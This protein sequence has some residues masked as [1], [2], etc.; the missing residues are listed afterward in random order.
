MAIRL[1]ITHEVELEAIRRAEAVGYAGGP[2]GSGS[3]P[4]ERSPPGTGV[5]DDT[6]I[7][8]CLVLQLCVCVY[9]CVSYM[10]HFRSLVHPDNPRGR[11][12]TLHKHAWG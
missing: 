7:T 9:M 8:L 3:T 5:W 2:G 12:C 6:W 11:D 4:L 10:G 1:L